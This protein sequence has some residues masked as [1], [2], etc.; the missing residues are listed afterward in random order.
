MRILIITQMY[1]QP[2]DEGD[3]KPTKT[4]NY[5]AKEWKNM[6]NEVIVFHCSSKFPLIMYYMPSSIKNMIAQN[7]SKIIPP[8][9]SRRKLVRNEDGVRVYR[10]P[11]FKL[12][13]GSAYSSWQMKMQ[14][15][16]IEGILREIGFSPDL[17]VGHFANPSLELVVRCAK[18]FNA[19]SS[20]VFHQDCNKKN[21]KKYRIDKNINKIGAIGVRSYIEAAAVKRLLSLEKL[22]FLCF[23]GV[24]DNA[25]KNAE[26]DCKKHGFKDGINFLYV[27]S[28]I[29]RKH[30]DK[31]IEAFSAV[32]S[33]DDTLRIIGGGPDEEALK[34][35]ANSVEH[36]G[37]IQF[38][39][40][41]RREDVLSQMKDANIF[42]LISSNEVF[43]MVYIEA[44][45]QGCIT[46]ASKGEGFDGI[47]KNGK[48]GFLC[49]PGN[50]EELKKLYSSICELNEDERN[51][52][53][54]EAINTAMSFSEREVAENYL[55]EIIE[56]QRI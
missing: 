16:R 9:K 30:L 17:V 26:T 10:S 28:L 13:P 53:G 27:G 34:Q 32:S 31:V 42:T 18:Y 4:V 45:L 44:M 38:L 54:Q 23:S 25:V 52:I 33:K 41:I 56:N 29:K 39:G 1:S 5:F 6:G 40:R 36:L 22:P 51:N 19:K 43:G 24:P 48:N 50:S 15:K 14:E 35:Y 37:K 21:L 8:L 49:E 12:L 55:N 11:M 47:I 46:I 3:N 7:T 20:I 2:D